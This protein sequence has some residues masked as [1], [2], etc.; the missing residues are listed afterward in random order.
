LT[1]AHENAY[2]TAMPV[3][4][5]PSGHANEP[6]WHYCIEC[7]ACLDGP[8]TGVDPPGPP[9]PA[10]E[11]P[12]P[13]REYVV[14]LVILLVALAVAGA[15][16]AYVLGQR[17]SALTSS[18]VPRPGASARR[19]S[20]DP[21]SAAV[22]VN[23][24]LVESEASRSAVQQAV[25]QIASCSDVP[26][27]VHSLQAAAS[28][29]EQ[30]FTALGGL[31][32]SGLPASMVDDLTSAWLNS[33]DSD[34]SYATWGEDEEANGCT[35][36]DLA[37][38]NYQAAVTTDGRASRSKVAFLALWNPLAQSDGLPQWQASQI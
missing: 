1:S 38:P 2:E 33:L 17:P 28:D 22:A 24:L 12:R 36:D 27:A 3:L 32:L 23:R 29:R 18:A 20:A 7:G 11:V 6:H 9:A 4:R 19:S 34:L 5:C 21:R 10:P 16:F 13:G 37:D 14:A 30:L 8:P 15:T 26:G 25:S 35:P 31:H